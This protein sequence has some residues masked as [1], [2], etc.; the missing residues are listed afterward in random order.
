M[1]TRSIRLLDIFGVQLEDVTN[2]R[3]LSAFWKQIFMDTH[4][5]ENVFYLK[6]CFPFL[7][8]CKSTKQG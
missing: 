7:G 6:A 3:I 4:L 8:K 1:Q 2:E 5:P